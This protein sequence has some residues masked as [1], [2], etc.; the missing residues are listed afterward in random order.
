[1]KL[2]AV[3]AMRP[4]TSVL[5]LV[6]KLENTRTYDTNGAVKNEDDVEVVLYYCSIVSSSLL[7][8][9]KQPLSL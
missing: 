2:S 6:R 8:Y 1:M 4:R 3:L 7:Y 5:W 9:F